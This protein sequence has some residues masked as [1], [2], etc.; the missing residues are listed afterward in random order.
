[1]KSYTVERRAKDVKELIEDTYTHHLGQA[2]AEEITFWNELIDHCLTPD[3]GA[4]SIESE[5][6]DNL[7]NLRLY[8]LM[9]MAISNTLWLITIT[10]LAS[11]AELTVFG[12]NP[13]SLVILVIFSVIF[14]IQ[15]LCVFVHRFQTFTHFLARA[16]YRCNKDY[17]SS[18][19][20]KGIDLQD[21]EDVAAI[22]SVRDASRRAQ[23]SQQQRLLQKKF[24][25][26]LNDERQRLLS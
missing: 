25:K 16:P 14:V 20:Y 15:F 8:W 22:S 5:L 23:I 11:Q 19:W 10:T 26:G 9:I 13:L 1:M 18:V 12:A 24:N 4:F 21:P 3:S 17:K 2:N 6:K 7:N